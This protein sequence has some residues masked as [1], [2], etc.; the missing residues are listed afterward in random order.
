MRAPLVVLL[1]G[2][3]AA[4]VLSCHEVPT[5]P[6]AVSLQ[7]DRET[8]V[9]VPIDTA[10][11]YAFRLVVQYHNGTSAPIYFARCTPS[12]VSPV[13]G[14]PTTD[15][16]RGSGWDVAWACTNAPV[17]EFLPGTVRTDS[18]L[19]RGPN[20]YNGITHEPLGVLAGSFRLEYQ[21]Y[22]CAEDTPAC[23]QAG[24]RV[25]SAPFQVRLP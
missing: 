22:Q 17:L 14:V 10:G 11:R 1:S 20:A 23:L 19:I 21:T 5:A 3:A 2:A 8:Y 13:Y 9:G 6:V 24:P 16:A 15:R 25:A 18:L 7:L 4:T 12:D